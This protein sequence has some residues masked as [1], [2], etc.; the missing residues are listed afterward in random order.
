MYNRSNLVKERKGK[1]K[2]MK[3]DNL[4]VIASLSIC[5]GLSLNI[6]GIEYGIDDKI[7]VGYTDE[8]PRKN[9]IYYTTSG[10]VY[11]KIYGQR[12]YI[13]DFMTW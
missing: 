11:F 1:G 6:Y 2:K 7:I 10:K 12:F 5:N 13:D 9:K 3:N 8:V 4:Q